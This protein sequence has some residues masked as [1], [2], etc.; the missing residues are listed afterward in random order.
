L[1][2]DE[3]LRKSELEEFLIKL[4]DGKR[5]LHNF[6]SVLHRKKEDL[7]GFFNRQEEKIENIYTILGQIIEEEKK[8]KLD[9]I[10]QNRIDANAEMDAVEN[11]MCLRLEDATKIQYDIDN[12]MQNIVRNVALEPFKVIISQYEIKLQQAEEAIENYKN[13][14]LLIYKLPKFDDKIVEKM[15][16][17]LLSFYNPIKLLTSVIKRSEF[18][19]NKKITPHSDIQV[20]DKG[21]IHISFENKEIFEN[22]IE[23]SSS[24]G[25]NDSRNELKAH[26]SAINNAHNTAI[27]IDDDAVYP[28]HQGENFQEFQNRSTVKGP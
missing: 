21:S 20:L 1:S 16:G 23:Q 28:A 8:R 27:K 24:R 9:I 26:L 13:Q 15:K 2:S 11:D 22:A 12:N 10:R 19:S 7:A 4:S 18:D 25:V 3:A 17:A 14:Q 6:L 5:N